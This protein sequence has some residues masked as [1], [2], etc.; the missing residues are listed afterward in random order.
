MG[1]L[2]AEGTVKVR[3]LVSLLVL[4]WG[5]VA[6]G[7]EMDGSSVGFALDRFTISE[8]GSDWFVLESLDFRGHLRGAVGVG[9]EW[10]RNSLVIYNEDDGSERA[11][12]VANQL[13]N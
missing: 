8:R 4:A 1:R 7:Q 6:A 9:V 12:L 5:G 10:A 2:G 3:S 13:V 11:A